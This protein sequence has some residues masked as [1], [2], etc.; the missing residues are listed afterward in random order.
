MNTSIL[1]NRKQTAS[2][3]MVSILLAIVPLWLM[4]GAANM[5][6]HALTNP[7]AWVRA[8]G[9]SGSGNNISNAIKVGP[10]NSFYITGQFSSTAQFSNTTLVSSGGS[11]IFIAKYGPSGALL[12]IVKAGGTGDDMGYGVDVDKAGN[13]Y[14]TG[15]FE[16][17]ATFGSINGATK[18]LTGAGLTIF[19]AKYSPSGTLLW[20]QTGVTGFDWVY[21]WGTAVAVNA[22]AGTV[23]VAALSQSDTTFSSEN[24]VVNTVPGVGSWHMVLAKYDTDGNFL[25]GQTNAAN[26]NSV[27]SE[28][29]VDANDNAYVAGWLENGTSFTSADGKDIFMTGFSPGQSNSDYPGDAFLAKYDSNGNVKW[30]NHVGGYKAIGN[31]VAVSPGGEISFA[32]YI[33]NVNYGSP[34]EAQTIVNSQL[35]GANFSLGG[36]SYT[37]PFNVDA[38]IVTYNAA[39]VLQGAIRRGGSGQETANSL[40]YDSWGNLYVAEP[41]SGMNGQTNLSVLKYLGGTFLS[42]QTAAFTGIGSG[43]ESTAPA[44]SVDAAGDV[45]LAGGYVGTASFGGTK[46][47]G[48]G[49]SEVFVAELNQS[50]DLNLRV[51]AS[52]TPITQ[53]ELL[54]YTFPVWNLG[55]GVATNEVLTTQVPAGT[56]FDYVRISGTPGLGTCT[57]PP[58]GGT[59][60]IV[61]HEGSTMAV[62]TTWT[63]RLTVRVTAP[64]GTVITE[65]ATATEDTPD[66]NHA[67]NTATVSI[68]VQ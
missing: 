1:S 17:S 9:S 30:V 16:S 41:S 49:T 15:R 52:P 26:P 68:K 23:Y 47:S 20:V 21:N 50:A 6:V 60:A 45:F 33:G 57:H 14:V 13:V 64:S 22:A 3:R 18:T 7:P 56:T 43:A 31:A 54:T 29:A 42:A 36:G 39:G 65:G 66:P 53:G 48:S 5:Q 67:N 44:V 35:P 61:C 19:L 38:F 62:N 34:S 8:T 37:S 58:Y 55:P 40:S 2:F 51:A 27:P 25:W 46:L 4:L 12:W 24:G 28:V 59:G 11:D 32:G 63:I 10:D